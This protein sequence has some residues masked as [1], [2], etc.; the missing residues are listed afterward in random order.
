MTQQR[1]QI[2]Q[3]HRSLLAARR[4]PLSTTTPAAG[5]MKDG[6]VHVFRLVPPSLVPPFLLGLLLLPGSSRSSETLRDHDILPRSVRLRRCV[7]SFPHEVKVGQLGQHAAGRLP[8]SQSGWP[9]RDVV[10]AI[11]L[12]GRGKINGQVVLLCAPWRRP[13][14]RAAEDMSPHLRSAHRLRELAASSTAS[15]ERALCETTLSFKE[16]AHPPRPLKC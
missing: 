16:Q 14:R 7:L 4:S 15:K 13:Q 3:T 1:I 5:E 11:G 8:P 9:K 6:L 2:I 12:V 10:A